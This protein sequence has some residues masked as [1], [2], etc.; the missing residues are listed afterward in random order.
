MSKRKAEQPVDLMQRLQ[1]SLA[2]TRGTTPLGLD[3]LLDH[4]ILLDVDDL[5]PS[6]QRK[7]LTD[8]VQRLR[9]AAQRSLGPRCESCGTPEGQPHG[10]VCP[11]V[12]RAEAPVGVPTLAAAPRAVSE[13][14]RALALEAADEYANG[15]WDASKPRFVAANQRT[16]SALRRLVGGTPDA[17]PPLDEIHLT[18]IEMDLD[19]GFTGIDADDVRFLLNIIRKRSG[20]RNSSGFRCADC[21]HDCSRTADDTTRT[22]PPRRC[23]RCNAEPFRAASSGRRDPGEQK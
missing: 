7:A 13:E 10:I 17:L 14:D 8:A 11:V 19:A 6:E 16:A 23:P 18:R 15:T 22:E 12:Q 5:T 2:P 20:L 4:H 1:E 3:A 9:A 21:G